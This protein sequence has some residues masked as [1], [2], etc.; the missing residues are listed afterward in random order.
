LPVENSPSAGRQRAGACGPLVL[1]AAV[2]FAIVGFAPHLSGAARAGV[3]L[4][5]DRPNLLAAAVNPRGMKGLRGARRVVEVSARSRRAT[6]ATVRRYERVGD[7]YVLTGGAVSARIGYNGLS[8]PVHRHAGD[9]TTPM[10]VYRFVY[11]F[12]SRP[13]PGVTGFRW[14]RLTRGSCWS[15]S[16]LHYNR[17]VRRDPCGPADEDLWSSEAVAYRYAAVISFNYRHPVFGR[18]SGIFLHERLPRP[19]HGCVSVHQRPLLGILRWIR[20]NAKI[21]IGT[22]RY[23]RS[24]RS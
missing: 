12:G 3:A 2:A 13:N 15:G 7:R 19:T 6:Y 24:L 1:V 9:D 23:L 11:D 16:R 4:R 20:P 22:P 14:R 10:G 5:S 18:G 17:W 21:V 8:R